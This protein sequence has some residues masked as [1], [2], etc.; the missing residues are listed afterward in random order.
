MLREKS[1]QPNRIVNSIFQYFSHALR[2]EHDH[3][4]FHLGRKMR[5]SELP[6]PLKECSSLQLELAKTKTRVNEANLKE[7]FQLLEKSL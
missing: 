4:S 7:Q 5:G 2:S 6:I 3:V 1:I